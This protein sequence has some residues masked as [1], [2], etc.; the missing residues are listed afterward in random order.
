MF[1]QLLR[2]RVQAAAAAARGRGQPLPE[3][4]EGWPALRGTED[5]DG[6]ILHV[7]EARDGRGGDIQE[8][9]LVLRQTVLCLILGLICWPDLW[10]SQ[11]SPASASRGLGLQ[12]YSATS[13][14]EWVFVMFSLFSP[15]RQVFVYG[16]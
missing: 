6:I 4:L 7:V 8:R 11:E 15:L 13:I 3:G 1:L 9:M 12:M 16:S 10:E 14:A 2:L 5:D